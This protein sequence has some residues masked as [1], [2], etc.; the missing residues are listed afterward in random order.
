MRGKVVQVK[1]NDLAYAGQGLGI[2]G[3]G[4]RVL[5]WGALP[6][7][8]VTAQ[9]GRVVTD[10][11]FEALEATVMEVLEKSPH[12]IEPEEKHYIISSPWQIVTYEK[13][14]EYKELIGRK[15][16]GEVADVG[17]GGLEVVDNGEVYGYRNS[18]DF[19]V[20]QDKNTLKLALLS[21]GRKRKIRIKGSKL[22]YPVIDEVARDILKILNDSEKTFLAHV[23]PLPQYSREKFFQNKGLIEQ[24]RIKI[25]ANR[26]GEFVWGVFDKE[27]NKVLKQVQ[28]DSKEYLEEKILGKSL[29]TGVDNF[30]QINPSMFEKT[31]EKMKEFVQGDN[32]VDYFGG[33]GTISIA[34]SD[35]I[36]SSV[37]VENDSKCTKWAGENIKLNKCENIKV[38][39]ARSEEALEYINKDKIIILNPP[40]E[41]VHESVIKRILEVSPKKIIYLSCK[42]FTQARDIKPLL[43]QY[44]IAHLE[45]YNFF[46]RTPHIESLVV[47]E[48]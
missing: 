25:R 20:I 42:P 21:R 41:G 46:P 14:L 18:M 37:I 15:V 38:E 29:R 17:V 8:T 26:N 31:V 35:V 11:G 4:Q 6:G 12:R 13:E 24:L 1:I 2:S 23:E 32:I 19:N 34:L 9:V 36:G 45:L 40:R 39:T 22:A 7:E 48:K 47:L 27:G 5:V 10:K 33:V 30:F 44:K 16:F 3:G 43:W 28:D